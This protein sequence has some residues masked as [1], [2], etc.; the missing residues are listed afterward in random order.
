MDTKHREERRRYIQ[1]AQSGEQLI[2]TRNYGFCAFRFDGRLRGQYSR[3][4]DDTLPVCIHGRRKRDLS[5]E[6]SIF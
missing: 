2:Y 6:Y 5:C 4:K 3:G 1:A